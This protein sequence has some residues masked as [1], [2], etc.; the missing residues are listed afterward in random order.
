MTFEIFRTDS[1]QIDFFEIKF[2]FEAYTVLAEYKFSQS[3]PKQN[4]SFSSILYKGNIQS[5]W[6]IQRIPSQASDMD[7]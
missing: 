2:F 5:G 1:L 4:D 6:T 3:G 7:K